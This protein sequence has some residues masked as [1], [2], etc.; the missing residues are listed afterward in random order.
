MGLPEAYANCP[1]VGKQVVR[2][3]IECDDPPRGIKP[4]SN[5]TGE[6]S[7]CGR[8]VSQRGGV[9]SRHRDKRGEV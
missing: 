8:I 7:R 5:G 6:C 4:G 1:G 3:V 2:V 9:A